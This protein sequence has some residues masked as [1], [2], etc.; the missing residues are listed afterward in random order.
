M[1]TKICMLG[2]SCPSAEVNLFWDLLCIVLS[3]RKLLAEI[4]CVGSG[5][6]ATFGVCSI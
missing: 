3:S 4:Q 5:N 6:N 2:F 1:Q